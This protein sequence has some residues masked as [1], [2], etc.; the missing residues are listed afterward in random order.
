MERTS[1]SEFAKID[2]L[3]SECLFKDSNDVQGFFVELKAPTLMMYRD[4]RPTSARRRAQGATCTL[5]SCCAATKRRRRSLGV[6]SPR[7]R[8]HRFAAIVAR[9]GASRAPMTRTAPTNLLRPTTR[10]TYIYIFQGSSRRVVAG[11]TVANRERHAHHRTTVLTSLLCQP[12]APVP[13]PTT[14]SRPLTWRMTGIIWDWRLAVTEGVRTPTRA[15]SSPCC[16]WTVERQTIY[17]V[18]ELIPR[19]S[20]S[21]RDK[22]IKEPKTTVTAANKVFATATG[23]IGDTSS[24]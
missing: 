18:D 1:R 9:T 4:Q 8:R 17:L 10:K 15:D 14:R 13:S 20:H 5:T 22:T 21:M 6:A 24:S 23:T 12:L 2:E 19:L 16:W 3:I 7:Q 11:W